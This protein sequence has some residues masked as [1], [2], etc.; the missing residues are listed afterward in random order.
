MGLVDKTKDLGEDLGQSAIGL[1]ND[2]PSIADMVSHAGT[3]IQSI[4]L[5]VGDK[6]LKLIRPE[7]NRYVLHDYLE[8]ESLYSPT[9]LD[10]FHLTYGHR[11]D[12]L[13]MYQM[14][15]FVEVEEEDVAMDIGAYI[16]SF[17][18][19][20]QSIAD[21][22][23]AVDPFSW[24]DDCLENN[25]A[26]L[27]NVKVEP[28]AAWKEN[29]P[30]TLNMSNLP[31]ENSLVQVDRMPAGRT[32]VPGRTVDYMLQE[33]DLKHLD[34]MKV[35]G[36]GVEPQILEGIVNSDKRVE[37]IVVDCSPEANGHSPVSEVESKLDEN[38]YETRRKNENKWDVPFVYAKLKN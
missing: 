31:R 19:A 26:H 14:D 35:E 37:K 28:Y 27:E 22:V 20:T 16:G 1:G 8:E 9:I 12:I 5:S 32:E 25:V 6:S 36:E 34:Y 3:A 33:A 18:L 4:N 15:G 30:V 21:E 11:K 2:Y 29:E 17:T 7:G 13:D 23:I 10:S 24:I 38:G